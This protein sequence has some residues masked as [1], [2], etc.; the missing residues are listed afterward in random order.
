MRRWMTAMVLAAALV[1]CG[2]SGWQGA[3]EPPPRCRV[4][5]RVDI[6]YE[7]GPIR[8]QRH[9]TAPEKMESV[10]NYLRQLHPYGTPEEDPEAAGGSDYY[11]TLFYS[12]GCRSTYRQKADRFW[13][14]EE[15]RWKKIRPNNAQEL[16]LLM[17]QLE[18]DP[19]L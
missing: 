2:C 18:S 19:S 3:G 14:E 12:D 8:A 6:A 17:G 11:I 5:T 9:Y 13:A 15:G 4:V 10:L 16:G 1:L 7:N